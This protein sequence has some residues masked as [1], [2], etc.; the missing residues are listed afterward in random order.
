MIIDIVN[1][2]FNDIRFFGGKMNTTLGNRFKQIRKSLNMTQKEFAESLGV[3]QTTISGIE[4]DVANSSLTLAK[5]I[6]LKYNIDEDW[7]LNGTGEM[8]YFPPEWNIEDISGLMQK[9]EA[10][11]ILLDNT[12]SVFQPDKNKLFNIVESFGYFTSIVSIVKPQDI[13]SDIYLTMVYQIFDKLEK[14]IFKCFFYKKNEN[15]NFE[16]MYNLKKQEMQLQQEVLQLIENI[17]T[18]FVKES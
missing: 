15:T 8:N 11:K 1:P 7:L 13:D 3:T 16:H 17:S 6:S 5:L 14:Y 4:K 9:F 2:I 12:V 18:L 10:M